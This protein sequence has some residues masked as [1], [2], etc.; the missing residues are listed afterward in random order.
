[1]VFRQ[2]NNLRVYNP[3]YNEVFNQNWIDN[4]LKNLRPY[5]ENFRFWVASG[6]KDTSRLLRGKALEE[7]EVWVKDKSLSYQDKQF[8]AASKEQEIQEKIAVKEQKA[9]LER[10]RQDKEATEKRNQLLSVANQK[11][12]QKIRNGTAVLFLAVFIAIILGVFAARE[13]RKLL[14]AQSQLVLA[15]K[16][17]ENVQKL[18]ELAGELRNENL[19]DESDEALRLAGLSF[20]VKDYN[21]K[22]AL[23]LASSSQAYQHL[24]K[25]DE[26]EKEIKESNIFLVQADKSINSSE[27]LQ[28]QVLAN[29]VKGSFLVHKKEKNQ[30]IE[31][32]KLA[33]KILNKNPDQT[34]PFTKTNQLLAA[35]DIETVHRNLLNLLSTNTPLRERVEK[36]LTQHLY[37]QLEYSLKAKNWQ[38]ADLQTDQLM[39]NIAKREKEEYLDLDSINNFSCPDLKKIDQLWVNSDKR[40]GFSVQKEIW[41]STGNRLGIKPEEWNDK[42]VENYYRF[43]TAVGWYDDKK[44]RDSETGGRGGDFLR[45]DELLKL[46]K[47]DPTYGTGSLPW[48]EAVAGYVRVTGPSEV[49]FSRATGFF[50][51]R[52]ATCKV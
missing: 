4:Q 30:A 7:A 27:G 31:S 17:V 19:T 23:L 22:Q 10:E 9:A 2:Q 41:I 6:G 16:D 32:Y 24:K 5:S 18:S 15:K 8:L 13:G 36:S 20:N 48:R 3:I 14:E 38:A 47:D 28:I 29:K 45:Y 51:S 52:A 43:A 12:Q 49:F 21:L 40:F 37:A 33:F 42:D 39:L 50:F 1:M 44:T 25:W 46:V 26:A 34:N 11:A 35:K